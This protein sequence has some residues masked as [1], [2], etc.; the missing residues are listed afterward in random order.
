MSKNPKELF[1]IRMDL[2][3]TSIK[4][5]DELEVVVTYESFGSVPTLVNLTFEVFDSEGNLIYFRND[6]IIV[7]VEEIRRYTFEDLDLVDG[8]YEFVLTTLY[9]IDFADKFRSKFIVGEKY[10]AL[11]LLMNYWWIFILFVLIGVVLFF[12]KRIKIPN[13]RK[14]RVISKLKKKSFEMRLADINSKSG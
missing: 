8:E 3:D 6:F 10:K 12:T 11:D 7:N 14:K 13:K 9:N 1:D 5:S 4:S 2:E